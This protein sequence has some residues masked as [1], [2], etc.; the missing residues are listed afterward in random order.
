M[1]AAQVAERQEMDTIRREKK[2]RD[3]KNFLYFEQMMIEGRR[4]RR[5]EE[6]RKRK[7]AQ[8]PE[9]DEQ[10]QE[11]INPFSGEKILPVQDCAF[12]RQ[13]RERR[14]ETVVNAPD[15]HVFGGNNASNESNQ[16][17]NHEASSPSRDSTQIEAIP[18]D[19]RRME[20]LHQCA[21]VG[22]AT[23][24]GKDSFVDRS[25]QISQA[26]VD[27]VQVDPVSNDAKMAMHCPIL[28]PWTSLKP[29]RC[30]PLSLPYSVDD[31]SS[32]SGPYRNLSSSTFTRHD[33]TKWRK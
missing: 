1:K 17:A 33:C 30:A 5:E 12:L 19:E 21:T 27:A 6:E 9:S 4:K 8:S 15:E 7:E 18:V 20:V 22:A 23:S 11:E 16:E 28:R 26:G 24:S 10:A 3:E 31:V 14:W 32:T 13:E 2:E 29:M 25:F